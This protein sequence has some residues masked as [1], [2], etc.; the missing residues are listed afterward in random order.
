RGPDGGR[1][2]ARG[3]PARGDHRPDRAQRRRQDHL[4]QPAD[5]LR[6]ARRRRLDVRGPLPRRGAGPP[7]GPARDGA[8]LPAHQGPVAADRPG[9][10]AARGRRPARR[11]PAARPLPAPVAL[12]GG[13][14]HHPRPRPPAAVQ[15]RRQ[16]GRLRRQ[17]LRGAAQAPG[18]G[19]GADDRA[20]DG[21]ARRAH[22]RGEPGADPVA[23]RPRQGP[24][25]GGHD[26]ALRRARHGHGARHLGLGDRHGAGQGRRRGAAGRRHGRPGRDR[27]LPR[28]APRRPAD[29]GGRGAPDRRDRGRRGR[30]DRR[31]R[32]PV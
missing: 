7:R 31:G 13:G 24:A 27:R 3:D 4:L 16:G 21:D 12:R 9:E 17:P 25:R 29:P 6:Q 15:A 10:H 26:G 32:P 20:R 11:E 28:R 19:E 18:D 2:R 5:G 22:G 1:R 30:R 23:A 8:H 14:Q